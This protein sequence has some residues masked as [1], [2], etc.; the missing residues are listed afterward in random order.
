MALLEP[1]P[2]ED[3]S[4]PA[5][6]RPGNSRNIPPNATVNEL[7]Y[8][9]ASR[10]QRAKP[11]ILLHGNGAIA[12]VLFHYVIEP[13]L[14]NSRNVVKRQREVQ[15]RRHERYVR[16]ERDLFLILREAAFLAHFVDGRAGKKRQ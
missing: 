11:W 12:E 10:D 5:I 14:R 8:E 3:F 15:H 2:N 13:E 4:D 7:L 9:A 6:Q 16:G 1:A